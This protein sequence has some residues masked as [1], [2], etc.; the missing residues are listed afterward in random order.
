MKSYPI[1]IIGMHRS[2]TSILTKV[3]E[4]GGLFL[5]DKQER[6]NEALLFIK[7]NKWIFNNAN[8]TWD[9]PYN[10][11]FADQYFIDHQVRVCKQHLKGI[12]AISYLGFKNLL[13]YGDVTKLDFP[14]GWKDPRNTF[15]VDVWKKIFPQLKL[16]HIY[17]NPIDVA[18]SLLAREIVVRS[19]PKNLR[20]HQQAEAKLQRVN[21]ANSLRVNHLNEGFNLWCD[22][23]SKAFSFSDTDHNNILHLKFE[24]VVAN[25]ELWMPQLFDFCGLNFSAEKYLSNKNQFDASRI[26]AFKN[27][28]ELLEFYQK[29]KTHPLVHQLGYDQL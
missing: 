10:L 5:G 16:V 27:N 4:E 1:L 3:L 17:R 13:K 15:T 26:N 28:N 12:K 11:K 29:I 19:R 23:T 21:Y 7:L 8:A 2:G 20:M 22:Y 6:N 25:P 24:D 14:F 9:L 18:Q